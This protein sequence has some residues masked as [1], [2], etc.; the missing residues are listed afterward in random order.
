MAF[1]N[2]FYIL[3]GSV[4]PVEL[5]FASVSCF[6]HPK[7]EV[8]LPVAFSCLGCLGWCNNVKRNGTQHMLSLVL[9]KHRSAAEKATVPRPFGAQA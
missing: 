2:V 4:G 6:T 7:S 5:Y 1:G 8:R 3:W 9:S